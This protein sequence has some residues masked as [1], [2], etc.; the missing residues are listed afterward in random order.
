M[1]RPS[2]IDRLP[3][4]VRELIGKLRRDGRTIDEILGK[5]TELDAPGA[6]Q[7]SRSALGRHVKGLDQVAEEIQRTRAV[8]NA[9]VDRF[10]AEPE[11]KTARLNIEL[12]HSLLMKLMM[13]DGEKPVELG[14]Q[15]AYF[16]GTALQRLS[17]AAKID[18]D[19]DAK[20]RERVKAEMAEKTTAAAQQ[21]TGTLKRA[22]LSAET[23]AT[24]ER[25]I[26]GIVR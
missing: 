1:P 14:S 10:G 16:L 21:A 25:E 20:I 13:G 6:Q 7:I 12:M 22:G 19:R 23:I 11:N 8:A 4:E 15:D 3:P 17:Q 18:V 9:I 2:S 24:I 5:L 26:L